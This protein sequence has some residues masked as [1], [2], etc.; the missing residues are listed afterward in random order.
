MCGGEGQLMSSSINTERDAWVRNILGVPV[1]GVGGVS[2]PKPIA[3]L[4]AS[5]RAAGSRL[6]EMKTASDTRLAQLLPLFEAATKAV[7]TAQ[8]DAGERVASMLLALDGPPRGNGHGSEPMGRETV[9][10]EA[11]PDTAAKEA[12]AKL[13]AETIRRVEGLDDEI[14][15]G[16]RATIERDMIGA[17]DKAA[18]AE[19]WDEAME[20]L[21]AAQRSCEVAEDTMARHA[22]YQ[23]AL[24]AA[25]KAVGK[26]I[27]PAIATEVEAINRDLVVAAESAAALFDFDEAESLLQQVAGKVAAAEI[28]AARHAVF[29]KALETATTAVGTLTE[30]QA[31]GD[32]KTLEAVIKA[33]TEDAAKRAFDDADRKLAQI[34]DLVSAAKSRAALAAEY[35]QQLKTLTDRIKLITALVAAPEVAKA[36]AC[37]VNAGKE[38]AEPKRDYAAAIAALQP[39]A[40]HCDVAELHARRYAAGFKVGGDNIEILRQRYASTSTHYGWAANAG[41]DTVLG[42]TDVIATTKIQA[43]DAAEQ[44]AAGGR[45]GEAMALLDGIEQRLAP[46]WTLYKQFDTFLGELNKGIRDHNASRGS[47]AEAALQ[48]GFDRLLPTHYTA[49]NNEAKDGKVT[50][51]LLLLADWTTA[52]A[53]IKAVCAKWNEADVALK[54]L[55]LKSIEPDRDWLVSNSIANA[56][57]AIAGDDWPTATAELNEVIRFAPQML[58]Y[59]QA[60]DAAETALSNGAMYNDDTK[61][62]RQDY[63]DAAATCATKWDYSGGI[64]LLLKVPAAIAEAESLLQGV[65][66]TEQLRDDAQVKVADTAID[67]SAALQSVKDILADLEK[68]AQASELTDEMQAMRDLIAEAETLIS[69]IVPGDLANSI[70]Y[71]A[72]QEKLGEAAEMGVEIRQYLEE[73]ARFEELGTQLKDRIDAIDPAADIEA[74]AIETDYLDQAQT[75]FD[76]ASPGTALALLAAGQRECAAAEERALLSHQFDTDRAAAVLEINKLSDPDLADEKAQIE[77]DTLDKADV[78]AGNRDF[79]AAIDHLK[80]VAEACVLAGK[81]LAELN[82]VKDLYTA[83]DKGWSQ[84][85]TNLGNATSAGL[86]SLAHV[87]LLRADVKTNSID[88]ANTIWGNRGTGQ[89]AL[90]ALIRATKLLEDGKT[91]SDRA[92]NESG[93]YLQVATKKNEATTALAE[94]KKHKGKSEVQREIDSLDTQISSAATL[95]GANQI[96][97]AIH[98]YKAII[99]ECAACTK[100]AKEFDDYAVVLT[101]AEDR[102]GL[103]DGKVKTLMP[104]PEAILTR[105]ATLTAETVTQAKAL[106][107]ARDFAAARTLLGT[108]EA[109]CVVLETLVAAEGLY[110]PALSAAQK[111]LAKLSA[112]VVAEEAKRITLLLIDPAKAAAARLDYKLA[113]DLLGKVAGEVA[114]ALKI[115]SGAEESKA[116]RDEAGSAIEGGLPDGIAAVE[117]L[118]AALLLHPQAQA[119]KDL[120]DPIAAAVAAV[121]AEPPPDDA[122]KQLTEAADR[123]VA[124]RTTAERLAAFDSH[125]KATLRDIGGITGRPLVEPEAKSVVADIDAAEK[126]AAAPEHKLVEATALV[127]KAAAAIAT[128]TQLI[129]RDTGFQE[130]LRKAQEMLDALGALKPK[131]SV[132]IGKQVE[133]LQKDR[134][135]AAKTLAG[136]P[137]RDHVGAERLLVGLPAECKALG[138][139]RM[140]VNNTP[141]IEAKLQDMLAEPGGS[142]A[143]DAMIAGLGDRIDKALMEAAIKVRFGL[144]SFKNIQPP[145]DDP[146]EGTGKS[147][148]LKKIY[149][150]LAKV[151][152]SHTLDNP[153]FAK[154]ERHGDE[155]SLPENVK[156]GSYYQGSKKK[157][158]LS[159]GRANDS[160]PQPLSGV[161]LALPDVE[162]DC[163]MVPDSQVPPPKYF[164]WTTLHEVGHAIDDKKRFMQGKAGDAAFGSWQTHGA[165]VVPVAKAVAKACNFTSDVAEAYLIGY[166]LKTRPVAPSA[167][168]GRND[169]D[170]CRKAAE[171]WC[172]EIRVDQELWEKGGASTSHAVDGRIYHEAYAGTW[173]SYDAAARTKGITGYQFRAPGEWLSELYAAYHCGKLKPSHPATPW[174][175]TL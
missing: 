52:R 103:C 17:A 29:A 24:Q 94:L 156:R 138:L 43:L 117:K 47:T 161:A 44:H 108:V 91:K 55:T 159:C 20:R 63:I 153:S 162:P 157:V 155:S 113:M 75:D 106:A 143:L 151:P 40:G 115:V 72:P 73:C 67:P 116:A 112:P 28:V 30:P 39:A 76:P 42:I 25:K 48:S 118:L 131:K 14:V 89:P 147:K 51:A 2:T 4:G 93:F 173:V 174:L 66:A 13:R 129:I 169:W 36:N 80:P 98:L 134:L 79:K 26:L 11:V 7:Q 160:D 121:K 32:R 128:A 90:D 99:E 58:A 109:R 86:P 5:L 10:E 71:V 158:V 70:D 120:T 139:R 35:E 100:I 97:Q 62:I 8:P 21:R 142:K 127:D 59:G 163:E 145:G 9:P 84:S 125:A 49:A 114:A 60:L 105:F 37:L 22:A 122:K 69:K 165:D 88:A 12:F 135:D 111:E 168:P 64:A 46:A 124:A 41:A 87:E 170:T 68:H 3:D 78:E 38:A 144:K 45:Y 53:L 85:G 152:D 27:D 141:P 126:L 110:R 101:P 167:P 18:G 166:L 92:W 96:T 132:T 164:D 171:T 6:Q 61:L 83:V 77:A 130:K 102:L 33:A 50:A 154:V 95:A 175:Q 150:L 1:K 148:S 172:D 16:D 82:K 146:V 23:L 34:G 54:T 136:L 81:I 133:A 137:A 65:E 56:L 74:Q 19:D 123:C 140:M 31:A 15:A 104:A 149:D 57:S 107:Q 119:I